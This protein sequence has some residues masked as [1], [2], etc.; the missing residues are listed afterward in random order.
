VAKRRNRRHVPAPFVVDWSPPPD[1]KSVEIME[2]LDEQSRPV[3]KLVHEFG[4]VIVLGALYGEDG[5]CG[6]IGDL[7]DILMTWRDRRQDAWL[8]T[9][10]VSERTLESIVDAAFDRM[11]SS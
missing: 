9:D 11:A 2:Q 3:R 5:F 6:S 1:P 7:L 10:Y 4:A 8:G